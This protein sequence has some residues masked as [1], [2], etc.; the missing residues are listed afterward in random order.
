M[1]KQ[2]LSRKEL[3]DLVWSTPMSTLAKKYAI[4]DSGLRKIC[5]RMQIPLPGFGYWMKIKYNKPVQIKKL[6]ENYT[7]ENEVSLKDRD[8]D[9]LVQDSPLRLSVLTQEIIAKEGDSL[10]VPE[11]LSNPHPIIAKAKDS[12]QKS[13]RHYNFD[14]MY[15]NS[16]YNPNINVTKES[17]GRALQFMD[18]FIKIIE[19]RGH[20]ISYSDRTSYLMIQEQKIEFRLSEKLRR[21]PTKDEKRWYKYDFFSTGIL[22]FFAEG[23]YHNITAKDGKLTLEK[24]LPSIIARLEIMGEK[25][26]QE[27]I[28]REIRR[29]KRIEQERIEEEK[30]E[31]K[32]K[33]FEDVKNLFKKCQQWHEAVIL[34]N[35]IDMFEA[36]AINN[37]IYT[38][39]VKTEVKWARSKADWYDPFISKVDEFLTDKDKD[40]LFSEKEKEKEHNSWGY[41]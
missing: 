35:Y 22:T 20:K 26:K 4:T 23:L 27:C 32:E 16:N 24:Q 29:Q 18:T 2:K 10:Y 7:S 25:L 6:S 11:R 19:K 8:D 15:Y 33:E 40:N 36:H 38:E 14:E 31:R 13:H 1:E 30:Q 41:Y 34:R 37:D 17:I 28:E 3:Y 39:A 9:A 12:F 5:L 21:E